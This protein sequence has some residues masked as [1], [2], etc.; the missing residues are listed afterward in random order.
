MMATTLGP[1]EGLDVIEAT[2]ASGL[3][4]FGGY[5]ITGAISLLPG[6]IF[7]P[8]EVV[9]LSAVIGALTFV[10]VFL[11]KIRGRHAELQ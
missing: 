7:T 8:A 5:V 6:S 1:A 11:A 2:V 9:P 4:G 3:V 10:G